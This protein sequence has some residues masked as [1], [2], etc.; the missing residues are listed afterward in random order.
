MSHRVASILLALLLG[1]CARPEPAP[2]VAAPQPEPKSPP[3]VIAP[4]V[5]KAKKPGPIPTRPLNVKT[6]CIFRDEAGYSGT[7]KLAIEQ[8][9]VQSFEARV[10]VPRRGSC[11]FNLKDF[12]QTRHLPNVELNHLH[13]RCI[14][15]V[16]EQGERV[17]VA[18]QQ[19]QKMCSGS[20]WEGL[21]PIL[22][23]T[24]SG[25]CA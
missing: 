23:D 5:P 18:F 3:V 15:H 11:R 4:A 2:P 25:T 24:R 9:R 1:A 21:W 19:C 22:T 16:W 14:V 17:T 6:D 7:M 20:A 8:A 12:R 10:D 13:D